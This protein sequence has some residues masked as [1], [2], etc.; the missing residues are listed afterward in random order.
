MASNVSL[1]D[2]STISELNIREL[3]LNLILL[4]FVDDKKLCAE[5]SD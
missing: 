3:C 4:G 2:S 1:G 5:I